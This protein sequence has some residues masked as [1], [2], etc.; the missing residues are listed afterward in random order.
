MLEKQRP[1]EFAVFSRVLCLRSCKPRLI[2]STA[3]VRGGVDEI[4]CTELYKLKRTIQSG[5]IGNVYGGKYF[6][7]M[8]NIAM[9]TKCSA[10][11]VMAHSVTGI[12]HAAM[13]TRIILKCWE[14][15]TRYTWT[16]CM[17][18]YQR[19]ALVPLYVLHGQ[20][21]SVLRSSGKCTSPNTLT[22]I[23]WGC[24]TQPSPKSLPPKVPRS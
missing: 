17:P 14:S 16:T 12:F 2:K 24:V 22:P 15:N 4:K 9:K 5:K 13:P 6:L 18:Q 1:G 8:N 20:V 19:P 10:I 21:W 3:W 7:W 23:S 11:T